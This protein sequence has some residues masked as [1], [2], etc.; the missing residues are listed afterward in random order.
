MYDRLGY[1]AVVRRFRSPLYSPVNDWMHFPRYP[2]H[3]WHAAEPYVRR[4][5]RRKT[6]WQ[7]FITVADEYSD[8]K[9]WF[10]HGFFSK[11]KMR[12]FFKTY[13]DFIGRAETYFLEDFVD[14][15]FCIND[16]L[17]Y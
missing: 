14:F 4:W 7:Q 13:R 17:H 2:L 9:N 5:P 3:D 1:E 11:F 15:R 12:L 10:R 8:E 6:S 16:P